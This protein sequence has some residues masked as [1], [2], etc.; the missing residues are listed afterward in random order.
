[1]DPEPLVKAVISAMM[2]MEQCG[3][4]EIDPDTAVHGLENIGHELL[5]L[6]ENDRSEFLD[7]L[8]RLA[9][10]ASD[11]PTA[12]FIRS[13]PFMLGMPLEASP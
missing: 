4:D 2:L 5:Q 8:E 12:R 7:L 11:E 1:M 13:V 10:S 6:S 3:P 9:T